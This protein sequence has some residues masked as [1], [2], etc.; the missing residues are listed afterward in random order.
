MN[1]RRKG[2]LR[3][4]QEKI[5]RMAKE[6]LAKDDRN[7]R[8]ALGPDGTAVL[9]IEQLDCRMRS[10]IKLNPQ[11]APEDLKN[12]SEI[13]VLYDAETLSRLLSD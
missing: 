13:P 4:I 11:M 10:Y 8:S 2:R 3:L 12:R 5:L 6:N 7:V 9:R 1:E